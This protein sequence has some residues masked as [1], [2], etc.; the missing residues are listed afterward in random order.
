[1]QLIT[2]EEADREFLESVTYYESKEAGLG[3]RFR[4]EVVA[5]VDWISRFPE[6]PRLRRKGYRRVN[7]HAF[8]HYVSY[9]IRGD[10]ILAIAHGHRRPEFWMDRI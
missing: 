4:N 9:L 7:L 10:K 6:T 2:L 8:P 5:V 3:I 1:M